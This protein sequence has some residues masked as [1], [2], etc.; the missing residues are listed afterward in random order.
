MSNELIFSHFRHL[1]PIG[2]FSFLDWHYILFQA[3]IV[4]F[5]EIGQKH[6]TIL[7]RKYIRLGSCSHNSKNKIKFGYRV[8]SLLDQIRLS[9]VCLKSKSPSTAFVV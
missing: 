7:F 5:S 4:S 1:Y 8:S 6:S 3:S 9:M 2:Y